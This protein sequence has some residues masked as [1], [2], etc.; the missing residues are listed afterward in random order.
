M[1]K[2]T[3]GEL[4]E[5]LATSPDAMIIVDDDGKIVQVN[6]EL[7]KLFGYPAK[8]LTGMNLDILLPERFRTVMK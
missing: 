8:A 7:V 3:K 5:F 4:L 1:L 6:K 2:T